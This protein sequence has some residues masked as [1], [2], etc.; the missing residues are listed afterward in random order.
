MYDLAHV[1]QFSNVE[2]RTQICLPPEFRECAPAQRQCTPGKLLLGHAQWAIV[3]RR[4]PFDTA[5]SPSRAACQCQCHKRKWPGHAPDV[6]TAAETD[7]TS[8]DIT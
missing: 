7:G 4:W 1:F 6:G 2:S 5:V 3:T 8:K